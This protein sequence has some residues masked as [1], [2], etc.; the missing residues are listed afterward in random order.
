M[1]EAADSFKIYVDR[2]REGKTETIKEAFAPGFMGLN[3]SDVAFMELVH[4]EGEAYRTSDVLVLHLGIRTQAMMPCVVCNAMA[5]MD[6]DIAAWSHA[7]PLRGIKSGTFDFSEVLREFILL[8]LPSFA[9]CCGGS[10]PGRGE[11]EKFLIKPSEAQA[12]AEA[13]E[14][15]RPFADL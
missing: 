2:L 15:Y 12:K 6:I 10:C 7:D 11:M 13:S 1:S 9:E 14:E 3:G 5:K 4:V 8:E